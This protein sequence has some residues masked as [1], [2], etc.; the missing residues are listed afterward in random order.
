MGSIRGG[1]SRLRLLSAADPASCT[2][3]LALYKQG[4]HSY[5]AIRG[6]I[7]RLLTIIAVGVL[8]SSRH[9]TNS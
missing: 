5:V 8:F 2:R 6:G 3:G 1:Y 7:A 4:D 9:P